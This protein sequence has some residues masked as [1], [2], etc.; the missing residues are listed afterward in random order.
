MAAHLA[1]ERVGQFFLGDDRLE[2]TEFGFGERWVVLLPGQLMTR[3]M[4]QPL[5]RALAAQGNHV[6]TLDPLG[7]G[8]SD[9]PEDPREYS[10]TAWAEQVVGLLDHLGAQAAV[11]GGTSLGANVSLEVATIAPERVRGLL[12]EMPVLDNAVETGIVAFAPMMFVARHLPVTIWATARASRLVPRR[13]VG[14]WGRVV[15]ETLEQRPAAMAAAIHGLFFGRVAPPA[16]ERRT[17]DRPALVVGH[18]A[19]PIHLDADAQMLVEELPQGTYVRAT[20]IL[21]WRFRPER[22]TR[23]TVEFV[24]EVYGVEDAARPEEPGG[25]SRAALP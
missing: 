3:T 14:H 13:V 2:Y 22:L 20:S 6:V 15:L 5:A 12:V 8:R 10:V 4:H 9:R 21:E 1:S 17:I 23:R 18:P 25:G 24:A 11:V 16:R 7:H 19:D